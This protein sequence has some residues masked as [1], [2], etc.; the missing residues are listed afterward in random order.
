MF[1]PKCGKEQ[2]GDVNYCCHCG[3]TLSK[4]APARRLTLSGSDRKI[5]GVCGGLAEYMGV[6]STL[7]RLVWVLLALTGVGLIGYPIA[8]LIMPYPPSR[9]EAKA[10][11]G[12]GVAVS[13]QG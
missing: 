8:W 3:A 1:C 2:Q 10:S 6:D 4:T 9:Q 7:V 12:Q 5:A 11:Q 13:S